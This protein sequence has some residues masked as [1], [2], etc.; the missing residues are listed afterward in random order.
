[1]KLALAVAFLALIGSMLLVGCRDSTP[2]P[3]S[4]PPPTA[5]PTAEA[6]VQ[7]I[8]SATP[9]S[10]PVYTP[11]PSPVPTPPYLEAWKAVPGAQSLERS[12]PELASDIV[13]LPWVEDGIE[14]NE[15]EAVKQLVNVALLDAPVFLSVV[16]KAWLTDGLDTVEREV[17]KDLA[18]FKNE[19]AAELVAAMPFLDT[20]EA[21]DGATLE[22]LA[23]LD[24]YVP[25]LLS[26]VA[27]KSWTRDGLKS[28]EREVI[29]LLWGITY[30][31]E[32]IAL[33]I[34]DMPFLDTVEP[35]DVTLTQVLSDLISY[36]NDLIYAAVEKSW[37]TDGLDE[38]EAAILDDL[39]LIADNDAAVALQLLEM[40]FLESVEQTD[41]LA[42]QALRLLGADLLPVAVERQW[43]D[44]G[45]DDSELEIVRKLRLIETRDAGSAV[46]IAAMPFLETIEESDDAAMD[47]LWATALYGADVIAAMVGSP[48][49]ADGIDDLETQAIRWVRNFSDVDIAIS[50]VEFAWVEDGIDE[51]E[52]SAIEELSYIANDDSNLAS[53]VVGF[54]WMQDGINELELETISWIGNFSN[55]TVAASVTSLIWVQNGISPQR[56][57]AI[58]ELSYL[59]NKDAA[60]ASRI[61]EMPFLEFLDPADVSAIDSLSNLAWFRQDDFQRVLSHPTLSDGITDDWAKI[62][63]TL[64]GVS[65]NKPDLIDT[66]LDP[67]QVTLEERIIDL[68]LAGETHLTIIRTG[69]GAERSMDL[70]DHATRTIEAYMSMPL[71]TNYVGLLF[72][73]AVPGDSAG[74][75]FGTHVGALAKYDVDDG[76]GEADFAGSLIAH[77]VAHYYWSGNRGWVDEGIAD[78]MGSLS[79]NTRSDHPIEVTNSP[80]PYAPNILELEA[81]D[82]EVGEST[83]SCNYALGERLF[84]DL[85]RSIGEEE[86]R[87]GLSNLYLIS[88]TED[89]GGAREDIELG[90]NHVKAAFT[91]DGDVEM[92]IVNT[93]AARW[94]DGSVPYAMPED[95]TGLT[96]PILRS[97]N[98]RVH[99][100]Y[101]SASHEGTPVTNISADAVDDY[102][103]LLL[104]WDYNVGSDTEVPLDLVH[105]YED[106]FEFGRRTVT[107]TADSRHNGSLWSWWLQVG[108]SPDK[109]WAIGNYELH[110]YNEGRK[111][112]ELEY[113][114]TE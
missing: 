46:Q 7:P 41:V 37:I 98:G 65:M 22:L 10:P 93:I 45:L 79:E 48:W 17:L 74:A 113:E 94:Y 68:P 55:P 56:T 16:D 40:P 27:D 101:L 84:I 100:A 86:F 3:M 69:P 91:G 90:I 81:L 47:A 21:A 70:L 12:K 114:V 32:A 89:E 110:V 78:F 67:N 34:L 26:A 43:V 72:E 2:A 57:R 87:R 52:V 109:P 112:V 76:S 14:S 75:N 99:T 96:N 51:L 95:S 71:P 31:D 66:L 25:G 85:Y 29:D 49:V 107:F 61:V 19:P 102:L 106:G 97:I 4:T 1:M 92:P 73:D 50:V 38:S 6:P 82:P 53:S 60:Q 83:Y 35:A 30:D 54:T 104:R 63:S 28:S 8:P 88:Q 58:E 44:D 80:C 24:F 39:K 36:R 111:L 33:R 11:T 5:T 105:Y 18:W 64:Y 23:D 103:W 42:L 62:V 59:S 15:R 9:V 108:Q 20:I 13:A 77:E